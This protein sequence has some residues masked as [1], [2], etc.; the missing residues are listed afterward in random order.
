MHDRMECITLWQRRVA[1]Q[2]AGQLTRQGLGGVTNPIA[3]VD[4]EYQRHAV[5]GMNPAAGKR[6]IRRP[7]EAERDP[8]VEEMIE[9]RR[10]HVVAGGDNQN[11]R[12]MIDERDGHRPYRN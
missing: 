10:G 9:H 11:R 6:Q 8:L 12:A 7:A 3:H 1:D 5:T 4:I 2:H